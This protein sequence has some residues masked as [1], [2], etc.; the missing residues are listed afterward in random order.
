M[1]IEKMIW[2]LSSS[3]EKKGVG[4][5]AQIQVHLPGRPAQAQQVCDFVTVALRPKIL[6][7]GGGR[8]TVWGLPHHRRVGDGSLR[9]VQGAAADCCPPGIPLLHLATLVDQEE[10]GSFVAAFHPQ[11]SWA[12]AASSHLGQKERR[13]GRSGLAPTV[14]LQTYRRESQLPMDLPQL[15]T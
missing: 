11:K 12:A 3:G 2:G 15:C 8:S 13:A 9:W 4:G 1:W 7:A 10:H 5:A 6:T 14:M